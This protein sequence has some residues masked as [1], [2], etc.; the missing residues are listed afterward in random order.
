MF[1]SRPREREIFFSR[2]RLRRRRFSFVWAMASVALLLLVLELLTRIVVDLS[3]K[4]ERFAETKTESDVMKAYRLKFVGR[5]QK[6]EPDSTNQNSLTAKANLSFGYQLV[7]NQNSKYW[8]INE[9]GFRDSDPVPLA[10]PQGEIRIFLLGGATAFGYGNSDNQNTISEHLE[11][12]LQ[13]RIQQ[14]KTSPQL[15]KSDTDVLSLDEVEKKKYLAKPAKIKSGNYRVINAAVPGYASGNELAQLALQLLNY[16]PDLV[17]ILDGYGDLML[18]SNEKAAQIP[19]LKKYLDNPPTGFKAYLSQVIQPL[20]TKSYLAQIVQDRWLNPQQTAQKADFILNEETA[21]LVQHLPQDKAELQKRVD[22]YIQHQKQ[23]LNLGAA[24][25]IPIV[26]AIQPEI[27]GRDPSQLTKTEGAIA[28]QLGRTYIKQAKDS[29]PQ[30]AAAIEQ[31][32]KTF[33]YNLKAVD[34]YNLTEEYPSPS[35]VDAVHLN[36]T[37]NQKVAEQLYYAISAFPKMQ[38]ATAKPVQTQPQVK[39]VIQPR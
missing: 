23:I 38:I 31:L 35:F 5:S 4:E 20:E 7:E 27:T 29:Y 25:R 10:K 36:E 3:G 12:R 26:V 8:Q 2:K 16:K 14:Q 30:F 11:K 37:A 18:P 13:E 34:L 9:Q 19:Q 1:K 21:N 39:G 15:Y 24:G 32:A 17:V 33:P 28:T 6:P 22:R